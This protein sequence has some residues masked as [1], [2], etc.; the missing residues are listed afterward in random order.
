LEVFVQTKKLAVKANP[1]SEPLRRADEYVPQTLTAWQS[2]LLT[3][4]ILAIMGA[5]LLVIVLLGKV[6]G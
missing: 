1:E 2:A 4:K 3:V 5:I 6:S